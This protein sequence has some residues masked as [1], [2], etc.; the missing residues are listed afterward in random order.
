MSSMVS[1]KGTLRGAQIVMRVSLSSP[2]FEECLAFAKREESGFKINQM[3][4]SLTPSL[5]QGDR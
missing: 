5:T 2:F 1:V 4:I 3:G